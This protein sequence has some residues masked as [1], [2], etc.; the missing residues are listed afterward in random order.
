MGRGGGKS[1]IAALKAT[2]AALFKR[3]RFAPGERGVVMVIAADR[4]QARVVYRYV[5]ALFDNTALKEMV[6]SRTAEAIHLRNNISVEI[7]TASFRA[8]RGPTVVC[9][10][11]DETQETSRRDPSGT[12]C[13]GWRSGAREMRPR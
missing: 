3:Y 12:S 1:R 6:T 8:V 4:R 7:H 5:A 2:E 10:I 13:G 9:C 11:A